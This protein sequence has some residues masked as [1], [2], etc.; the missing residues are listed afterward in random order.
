[1]F[2]NRIEPTSTYYKL[3]SRNNKIEILIFLS[4]KWKGKLENV[5]REASRSSKHD[6]RLDKI[7]HKNVNAYIFLSFKQSI[8]H[9]T[10]KGVIPA[11]QNSTDNESIIQNGNI[12][13]RLLH[14]KQYL[15]SGNLLNDFKEYILKQN[16]KL[17]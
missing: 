10:L 3:L 15:S 5:A 2:L 4:D 17:W 8:S 11:H 1:M 6:R 9:F 16:F 12:G 13:P 14:C 7:P